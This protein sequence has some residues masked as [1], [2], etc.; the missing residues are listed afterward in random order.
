M[1]DVHVIIDDCATVAGGDVRAVRTRDTQTAPAN[2]RFNP[3]RVVA[4]LPD[5]LD[6]RQMDW[7]EIHSAIFAAD[8]AAPRLPGLG[9]NRSIELHVPVRDPKHW[10]AFNAAFEDVFSSLTYDRLS[11]NFH[12]ANDFADPPRQRQAAFPESDCIALLSGGLDSFVGALELHDRG[13][14]PLFLAASGSGATNG[15]QAAVFSVIEALDPTRELLKLVCQRRGVFPGDEQSQRSRSFLYASTAAL[16]AVATGVREVYVNENGVMAVHLPLTAARLGS[17]STRTATP[18]VLAQMARLASDALGREVEIKNLL[19]GL[20]K[21]EVVE[22]AKELGHADTVKQTVSC[23]SISHKGTHCGY[24]SP[25]L[26]RRVACLQHQV[27]DVRYDLDVLGDDASLDRLDAK[28]TLV[29]FIEM[30]DEFRQG[31][32]F[33]L[34]LDHPDLINGASGIGV[35]GTLALYRRWADEVLT[36]FAAYPVPSGLMT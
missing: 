4:G 35:A 9:W 10:N 15:S 33:D 7:L 5:R 29:H 20:T 23:W 28:D 30:A 17:F 1:A 8:R 18:R 34:E 27:D 16:V 26:M 22:R 21:S 25:C 12:P 13:S 24:C 32:D 2:W 36:T 11:L 3:G 31:D 19:V 14:K 6:G